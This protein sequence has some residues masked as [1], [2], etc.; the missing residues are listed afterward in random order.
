M[1]DKTSRG[2]SPLLIRRT[3]FSNSISLSRPALVCKDWIIGTNVLFWSVWKKSSTPLSMMTS[4]SAIE[5]SRLFRP[6]FTM[7]PKSSTE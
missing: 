1:I 3:A 5:S 4:A 2:S 7:L 6:S